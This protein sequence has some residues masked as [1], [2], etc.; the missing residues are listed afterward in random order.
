MKTTKKIISI[1]CALLV[2]VSL[3]TSIANAAATLPIL[4]MDGSNNTKTN[5]SVL[6]RMLTCAGYSTKGVDGIFGDNTEKAVENFQKKNNLTQDG[7]VGTKTWDK[8]ISKC[9]VLKNGSKGDIVK[10]IQQILNKLGYNC[11]K[12]DGKFGDKTEEAVKAFQKA[13]G[14]KQDGKVGPK[15]WK[16]LLTTC[17]SKYSTWVVK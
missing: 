3:F 7:I 11:G 8:L 14:L 5:V 16:A 9:G 13:K 6:Q 15:T 12:A 1:L 10:L 4:K 2:C 17:F